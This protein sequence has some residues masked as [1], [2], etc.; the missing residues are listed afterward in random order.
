MANP[1]TEHLKEV[2]ESYGEHFM[3]ASGFGI[4]MMT[5]GFICVLHGILPFLF[6][7]TASDTVRALHDEMLVKRRKAYDEHWVI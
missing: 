7:R 5:A 6:K 3:A 2:D 1:T 4:R